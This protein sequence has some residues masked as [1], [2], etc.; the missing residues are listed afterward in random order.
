MMLKLRFV[1]FLCTI[2]VKDNESSKKGLKI[3]VYIHEV[4]RHGF[5]PSIVWSMREEVK[6]RGRRMNWC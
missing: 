5:N 1:P 3:N 4:S 2:L 6:G